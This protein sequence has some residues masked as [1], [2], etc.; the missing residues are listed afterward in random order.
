MTKDGGPDPE[1][2]RLLRA[3]SRLTLA[4]IWQAGKR[5]EE[6]SGEEERY[7]RAMLE[8]EEYHD[9]WDALEFIYDKEIEIDGV[10][11][12]LHVTFHVIIEGQIAEAN[13]PEVIDALERL[14][15]QGLSRHEAI[16]EIGA[17]FGKHLWEALKFKRPF[18]LAAYAQKL[19]ELSV[20]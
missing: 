12:A 5:G 3:S 17:V 2:F 4:K 1:V 11:P 8:H 20:S 10:N 9:V 19:R 14:Q 18:N 15:R 16:H 7:Y 13:P 6:L